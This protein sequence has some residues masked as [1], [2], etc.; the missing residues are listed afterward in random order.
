M[1]PAELE[2][3]SL[4]DMFG[5]TVPITPIDT[6]YE[7]HLEGARCDEECLIGGPPLFIV[8]DERPNFIVR[9]GEEMSYDSVTSLADIISQGDLVLDSLALPPT[10]VPTSQPQISAAVTPDVDDIISDSKINIQQIPESATKTPTETI[11]GSDAYREQ[12]G[13]ES[14]SMVGIWLIGLGLIVAAGLVLVVRR[15]RIVE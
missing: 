5:H 13:K 10:K 8:E 4:V 11:S 14:T 1:V 3:A 2:K 9:S 7:L 15:G 12:S 6:V